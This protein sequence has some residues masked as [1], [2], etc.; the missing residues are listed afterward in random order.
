METMLA[1]DPDNTASTLG[2]VSPSH[3]AYILYTSGSTGRPKGVMIEHRGLS[4]LVQQTPSFFLHMR[5]HFRHMQA[6]A[7]TF[8][9]CIWDIFTTLCHGG[10]L[11]LRDE[12]AHTMKHVNS[13]SLTPSLMAVLD[14]L[15]YPNLK[16]IIVGGERLPPDVASNWAQHRSIINVYG[17]TETTIIATIGQYQ[18]NTIITI[19]RPIHNA[20]IHILDANLRPVPVGALGEL[21]IGGPG[22]MRGYVNRPDLDAKALVAHPRTP[23]KRLFKTG[24]LGRWLANGEIECLGRQ[25]DQVKIRGMRLEL[26]EIE[27][28]LLRCPTVTMAAVLVSDNTLYAFVYPAEVEEHVAKTYLSSQLPVYMV[29]TRIVSLDVIPLTVNEKANKRALLEII[30]QLKHQPTPRSVLPPQTPT[31]ATIR[32]AMA[33][34]LSIDP[35]TIGIHDAFFTL[36]GD[37]LSAIRFTGLCREKGLAITIGQV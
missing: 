18:S 7:M 21:F 29:P 19:G 4:N 25:D 30:S 24:D 17:P 13:T 28:V 2:Q 3:L 10:T 8:D 20:E 9:G 27:A 31:Q 33:V 36:G 16:T 5:S 6:L 32:E 22:V 34:A 35:E 11:V 37:S 1:T 12:I 23:D 15:L 14:P 26:Q